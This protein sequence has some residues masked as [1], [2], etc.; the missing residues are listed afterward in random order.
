MSKAYKI[1]KKC[2]WIFIS[3]ARMFFLGRLSSY[4]VIILKEERIVE[5]MKFNI[6]ESWSHKSFLKLIFNFPFF[7]LAAAKYAS[8]RRGD[9]F[10]SNFWRI[11]E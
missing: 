11:L 6:C 7:E 3:C 1:D 2:L 5:R 9:N 8:L 10:L 4:N